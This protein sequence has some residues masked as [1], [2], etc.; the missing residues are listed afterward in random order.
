MLE[1]M[2]K[3]KDVLMNLLN[4]IM[5]ETAVDLLSKV[6]DNVEDRHVKWTTYNN[7]NRWFLNWE[8]DLDELGFAFRDD[9]GYPINFLPLP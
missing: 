8:L 2:G 3:D 9:A 5:K 7:L 6:T 4:L 1:V